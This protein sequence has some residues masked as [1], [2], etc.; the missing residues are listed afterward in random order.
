MAD[1]LNP[2]FW[3][4]DKLDSRVREHLLK[5]ASVFYE[6]LK[7]K[8]PVDD[9][10]FT[11][12]SANYNWNVKSD[13][14]LH[15]IINYSKIDSDEEF[16]KEYMLSHKANW[17]EAHD[18]HIKKVPVEVY[19]QNLNEK[20]YAGGIYSVLRDEW[21]KEPKKENVKID[22]KMVQH[23]AEPVKRAI[24]KAIASNDYDKMDKL[25]EK[26]H[27]MRSVGLESGG[28]FSLENLVYKYLRNEGYLD[29]IYDAK[30]TNLDSNLSM[31]KQMSI[32]N[33]I[34]KEARV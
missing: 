30:Q 12:S 2:K 13:I 8:Q 16:V 9:I 21:I 33:M 11:G 19:V 10:I 1:T 18:V 32:I 34:L 15:L 22:S 7:I 3:D 28:E 6:S 14:D 26:I 4:G 17:N 5:I 24:D 27:D 29:K 23:K 31:E 20:L 25:V